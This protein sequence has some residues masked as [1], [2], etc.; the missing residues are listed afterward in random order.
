MLPVDWTL[1]PAAIVSCAPQMVSAPKAV[2][3]QVVKRGSENGV[4][5]CLLCMV[6]QRGQWMVGHYGPANHNNWAGSRTAGIPP[7]Y[8]RCCGRDARGPRGTRATLSSLGS[9]HNPP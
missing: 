7:T 2:G 9:G 4:G 1:P 6:G 8:Y 5:N 3:S